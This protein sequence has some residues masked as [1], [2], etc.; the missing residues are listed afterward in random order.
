MELIEAIGY[1]LLVL[2]SCVLALLTLFFAVR[3]LVRWTWKWDHGDEDP[4]HLRWG[5]YY[6]KGDKR[7]FVPNS[8]RWGWHLNF[9]NRYGVAIAV[10]NFSLFICAV[11]SMFI[12]YK[13]A[14]GVVIFCSI[15]FSFFVGIAYL[16]NLNHQEGEDAQYWHWGFYYNKEDNF[17]P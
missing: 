10:I 6:N 17:C 13:V 9:G 15:L 7:I 3:E 2:F 1:L 12:H 16:W 14:L 4:K 5:F 8:F 11:F